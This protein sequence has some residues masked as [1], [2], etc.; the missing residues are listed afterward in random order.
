MK[1]YRNL[2]TMYKLYN[3]Y[4]LFFFIESFLSMPKEQNEE[5]VEF[6]MEKEGETQEGESLEEESLRDQDASNVQEIS[7]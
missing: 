2:K 4:T 6:H 5:V 3:V 1:S 7:M